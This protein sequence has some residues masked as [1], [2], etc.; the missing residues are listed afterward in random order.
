MIEFAKEA[1]TCQALDHG[2]ILSIRWAHDDPNPIAKQAIEQADKDAFVSLLQGKG[3][4]LEPAPFVYP[5]DYQLP[6]AKRLRLE[7]GGDV[8]EQYPELAYPDTDNQYTSSN[9]NNSNSNNNNMGTDEG[10]QAY[11]D[12]YYAQQAA[13]SRLGM[14]TTANAGSSSGEL[15]QIITSGSEIKDDTAVHA[16][17]TDKPLQEES[18]AHSTAPNG[19]LSTAPNGSMSAVEDTCGWLTYTDPSS[20]RPYYY[21]AGTGLTTW[22]QPPELKYNLF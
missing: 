9:S 20:G 4:S 13:L 17:S 21:N 14:I 7:E 16:V 8:L 10:Y 12:T 2:E 5:S 6:A 15:Q 3:V 22:D 19:S 11:L 1:M 18:T